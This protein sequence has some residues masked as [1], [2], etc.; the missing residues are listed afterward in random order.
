M[1][2]KIR[3]ALLATGVALPALYAATTAP[4]TI[5][6]MSELRQA[7]APSAA[8]VETADI[9]APPVGRQDTRTKAI[10]LEPGYDDM[11]ISSDDTAL[12]AD[13]QM[14]SPTVSRSLPVP[15]KG[16]SFTFSQDPAPIKAPAAG[17][18]GKAVP[19]QFI[20]RDKST[21]GQM[22]GALVTV[23]ATGHP[24]TVTVAN[25][26]EWGTDSKVKMAVDAAAG[27]VYLPQQTL[28]HNDAYGNIDIV[29]V[30][31]SADGKYSIPTDRTIAGT[32]NDKGEVTLGRWAVV[33]IDEASKKVK[34]TFNIFESSQWAVPN[35]TFSGTDG[36]SG[37]VVTYPMYVEQTTPNEVMIYHLLDGMTASL[38]ARLTTAGTV[39]LSPQLV[40]QHS[41]Y[42]SFYIYGVNTANGKPDTAN[43]IVARPAADGSLSFAGFYV[44]DQETASMLMMARANVKITGTY[45]ISFP[46]PESVDFKGSG[47]A[48]DPWLISTYKELTALSQ[49]VE[50]GNAFAGRHFALGAD[51]DLSAVPV[52]EYV[53]VGNATTH[54]AGIFD[55][56]GHTVKGLRIDGKG[57]PYIGLFGYIDKAG[58]VRNLVLDGFMAIG[59]GTEIGCVA[60]RCEGTVEGV[61]VRNSI[62]Q[63][64]GLLTGGIC[65]ALLQGTVKNSSFHGRITG[66]GSIAGIA[67][68]ASE[69]EITGCKVEGQFN[70]DGFISTKARDVGG[71]A[72]VF[73]VGT[74]SDCMVIGILSD[75]YGRGAIGGLAGRL[76]TRG[77]VTNCI[78]AASISGRRLSSSTSSYAGGLFGLTVGAV[79]N[80]CMN[81]GTIIMSGD[82]DNVG[83]LAGQLSLAYLH[84]GPN[85]SMIQQSYFTNCYNSGQITSS[86]TEG[87]K[88]IFGFAFH[89]EGYP[90]LPEDICF[91]NCF[92]DQQVNRYPCAKFGRN[93]RDITGRLPEGYSADRWAIASGKYPVLKTFA[94]TYAGALASVPLILREGDDANK[95]KVSFVLGRSPKVEWSLD[96]ESGNTESDA[97]SLNGSLATVKDIYSTAIVGA[98]TTDGLGMKLYMLDVVPKVFDGDGTERSPYLLKTIDDFVKLHEAISTHRQP[99]AGDF[100]LMASDIDF[101]GDTRFKG[102]GNGSMI[103][104]GFGGTFDGGGH[105]IHNLKLDMATYK[106]DG[107]FDPSCPNGYNGLFNQLN[108]TATVKNL[109]IA[110]DCSFDFNIFSGAIVAFNRGRVENCRN[111]AD[112]RGHQR[113]IGGI[114]GINYSG[115][116]TDC[117]NAGNVTCGTSVA[118]GISGYNYDGA[119]IIRCQNDGDV[120]V[121]TTAPF[122]AKES[123]NS[124]GGITSDNYGLIENCVNN[125]QIYG[126]E[127]VGGIAA[128]TVASYLTADPN[129]P[130]KAVV[131]ECEGIVRGCINNGQIN[132][133][134][135]TAT[136]GAI[137]GQRGSSKEISANYYDGS[138]NLTGG[139][140][141]N[142]VE[143]TTP[144]STSELTGGKTVGSLSADIFDFR[145]GAYP[146]LK[147]F[148]NEDASRALRS[149]FVKFAPSQ[150]RTNIR[151]SV[152]LSQASGLK[153]ELATSNGFSISGSTLNVVPPTGTTVLADTLTADLGGRYTKTYV[154]N[155]VPVVF[156]GEGTLTDPYRIE[157][158]ADWKKL[159]EFVAATG[160][161]YPNSHFIITRDID[162]AG[163]SIQP[164]AYN[165]VRFQGNLNGNGKTLKGFVY[166]NPNGFANRIDPN[167]PNKFVA[168]GTGL[169]GSLGNSGVIRN[170]TID[171]I[172]RG[173]SDMGGFAGHV[174][175]TIENCVNRGLVGTNSSTSVGGI[176]FRLYDGGVIR[177]CVN[178]GKVLPDNGSDGGQTAA[179]GIAYYSYQNSLIE[180]CIN[181]GEVGHRLKSNYAGIVLSTSGT[182]RGCRNEKTL[183]GNANLYG[184][185]GSMAANAVLEDCANTADFILPEASNVFGVFNSAAEGGTGYIKGCYNT[186]NLSV[187]NAVSGVGLTSYMPMTDCYNTG[188]ITSA[189][190]RAVGVVHTL[191]VYSDIMT[192]SERRLVSSG[193][194]N[195]GNVKGAYTEC[196]G[197][198]SNLKEYMTLTDSYNLGNVSQQHYGLCAGGVAACGDGRLERSFNAGNVYSWGHCTGGVMGRPGGSN[199]DW[200]AGV[201][202]CFNFGDVTVDSRLNSSTVYGAAGGIAGSTIN[203]DV[204]IENCYNTGNVTANDIT[205]K[206]K[207]VWAGGIVGN[208]LNPRIVVSNC[209]NAGRVECSDPATTAGRRSFTVGTNTPK[210]W[211]KPD[212]VPFDTSL[213]NLYY[214][215]TVNTG[216]AQREIQ[217]SGI[218]SSALAALSLDGFAKSSHGG[219]PMLAA[220]TSD[221]EASLMST[222]MLRLADDSKETHDAIISWFDLIA[223]AGAVWKEIPA[224]DGIQ[225]IA[226]EG[227][228]A[229]PKA[230]GTTTLQCTAADGTRRT[231][232]VTIAQGFENSIEEINGGKIIDHVDYIDLQG[233][234]ISNPER[235][236]VYIV[237]TY[238][239]DGTMHVGKQMLSK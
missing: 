201:F 19:G 52:T 207:D 217:G 56:K 43:P 3:I 157:S 119:R 130:Q 76:L 146:V 4:A 135:Q 235:G 44:A 8:T 143:G 149:I 187:K 189:N 107:D 224:S 15:M 99:H 13:F 205:H 2:K 68:Q 132:C 86:S 150:I 48:A 96:G 87:N 100:F 17:A 50:G 55:G 104:T 166:D 181:R 239:T 93:T 109:N 194:Y 223:P 82:N 195:T 161:E 32:I 156:A 214:D 21:N 103:S 233:R 116:I 120:A 98:T 90:D 11:A 197:V 67:G 204:S 144:L 125:G 200:E 137:I 173:H 193:L 212:S 234:I 140:Q 228:K 155:S 95:V 139:M 154:I 182:I 54:F 57:Y 236:N 62:L 89:E 7:L 51:L 81:S 210:F 45:D 190:Q 26:F 6:F 145:A 39:I 134:G 136:R 142:D 238:Y 80:D 71:I 46:Q 35:A 117:Y 126:D 208:V 92:F 191:G 222:A 133:S 167:N 231:F 72:G 225:R 129:N 29:A 159:Y 112:V 211:V 152:E 123:K 38:S 53:P 128:Y 141:S 24:D 183:L 14:E 113:Q 138:I 69:S 18:P 108:P 164:V 110:A 78:N 111:Y 237:R 216:K 105:S 196:A 12:K 115:V 30:T 66:M 176:A 1:N 79:V 31:V 230:L 124:V 85:V 34:A 218:T 23:E 83:G 175:G 74:M 198:V 41:I 114:A 199:P 185:V 22:L 77:T 106:A 37:N 127:I 102:F 192:K 227:T 121:R 203:G 28:G 49:A 9:P 177:G 36:A 171:G 226:I 153:W 64:S 168:K 209:Y 180:N 20:S 215:R 232:K 10:A 147:T 94:D 42:G 122:N 148:A 25:L 61:T 169:F 118:G 131:H 184:I 58:A 63:T 178:E 188:D 186:G 59:N 158:K 160:W 88:G 213:K 220:F 151:E 70:M 91:T 101:N 163:D 84:S 229:L 47:T 219:Y 174:Y 5:G 202:N 33:A 170:L 221:H 65:G 162:F 16:I 40:A 97:L 73:S 179:A 206:C 60:G 75:T 172:I 27:R 165:G